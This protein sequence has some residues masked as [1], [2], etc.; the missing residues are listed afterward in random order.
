MN[1]GPVHSLKTISSTIK[2]NPSSLNLLPLFIIL[3]SSAGSTYYP[4]NGGSP[5]SGSLSSALIDPASASTGNVSTYL[6]KNLTVPSTA[7]VAGNTLYVKGAGWPPQTDLTVNISAGNVG[8]MSIPILVSSSMV[9][10][11]AVGSFASS[12][13]LPA[14]GPPGTWIVQ[15]G[16]MP[17]AISSSYFVVTLPTPI[18]PNLLLPA[19]AIAIIV[20]VVIVRFLWMRRREAQANY[21]NL[22]KQGLE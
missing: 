13:K 5:P 2:L 14:N 10:T 6:D 12:F 22:K 17:N 18:P 21:Y 11:D 4:H 16:S 20:A 7:F 15:A 9:Q 8:E 3:L 19:V 1:R